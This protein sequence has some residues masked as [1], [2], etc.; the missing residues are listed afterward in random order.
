MKMQTRGEGGSGSKNPNFAD[1][2]TRALTFSFGMVI[3]AV[4]IV[5]LHP[6]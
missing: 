1:I 6:T 2:C 4:I 3:L 5:I